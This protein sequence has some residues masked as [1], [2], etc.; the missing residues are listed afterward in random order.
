MAALTTT[1]YAILS[2][3]AVK[4]WT[5]YELKQQMDRSLRALWPRA[6]S[7]LY[8]EPKKLVAHGL[9]GSRVEYTGRRKSTIYEIT[10]EGRAAL[11][12]WLDEPG[13]GP[14]LEFEALVQVAFA[15]HGNIEQLRA[16]LAH[17]RA[18]AEFARAAIEER[19]TEYETTGGP[20]PD[21][22][23]V[24]ALS[25]RFMREQNAS[26]LRWVDWAEAEV[27][28]WSG[29]TPATGARVPPDGFSG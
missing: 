6:G 27:A 22:L 18:Y 1:S 15:D 2:L 10:D 29:T 12:G 13:A 3:M 21:R 17:I 20:Y 14:V 4:P 28:H 25:A 26:L 23:P 9:A 7:V 5:T 8:E 11:R 24:I 16:V 19:M